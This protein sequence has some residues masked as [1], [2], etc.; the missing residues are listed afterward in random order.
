MGEALQPCHPIHTR[1]AIA[2]KLTW[3]EKRRHDKPWNSKRLFQMHWGDN[4]FVNS[5]LSPAISPLEDATISPASAVT[6]N[7][8]H[9]AGIQGFRGIDI[10]TC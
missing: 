4:D 2:T 1:E 9:I 8:Y 5:F 7:R 6:P 10:P 3:S